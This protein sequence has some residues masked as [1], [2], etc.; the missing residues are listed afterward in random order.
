MNRIAI[1]FLVVCTP[2]LF[3]LL[4]WLGLA[5]L[6]SNLFGWLLL[7]LGLVY[8]FG[9]IVVYWIRGIQFWRPRAN[10]ETIQE[11]RNDW[12]FWLIA[13]GM[14]A[15]FYLPPLEYRFLPA[16][17]PRALALQAAGLLIFFLGSVLF[18][19]A[20]RA[21]GHFYSG[22]VSVI[23]GQPLMQ[24]GPY[25]LIRHPAYAGYLLITL[26]LALGYSSLAGFASILLLLLPSMMYRIRVEDKLLAEHFG[27]SFADYARR[28]KRL[29]PRIW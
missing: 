25:R 4:A 13:G 6:P 15:A 3:L 24:C 28:V 27:A 16:F 19:W 5:T 23:E 1:F 10:G 2:G 20:R 18:I 22:H 26:G 7:V 11:E 21:L 29:L 8:L 9:V 14:I 17:L 12:S